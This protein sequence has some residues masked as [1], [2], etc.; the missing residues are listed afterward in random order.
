M[1]AEQ[2][3]LALYWNHISPPP[4]PPLN[5][6][7]QCQVNIRI[8]CR[9]TMRTL[10]TTAFNSFRYSDRNRIRVWLWPTRRWTIKLQRWPLPSTC[11]HL[12]LRNGELETSAVRWPWCSHSVFL[13][14]HRIWLVEELVQ[15]ETEG[16]ELPDESD[17]SHV[18]GAD[19]KCDTL[20]FSKIF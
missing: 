14:S 11:D 3:R 8:N 16:R 7:T 5:P 17:S 15:W 19:D 2:H 12:C 4:P 1:L 10:Q 9:Y 18:R 6:Y 13:C 20:W